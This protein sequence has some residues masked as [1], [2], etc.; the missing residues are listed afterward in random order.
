MAYWKDTWTFPT[1]IEYEFKFAGNYGAKGEKREKKKKATPEQIK[2]QN[3]L[4]REKRMRRLIEANFDPGDLWNTLKYPKGT[5]KPLKEVKKDMRKFLSDLRKEYKVRG[6][7]LRFVC[8]LHI[9]KQGGIHVHILV[10]RIRGQDTD[11]IIQKAWSHGQVNYQSIND[12]GGYKKLANYIVK[13]LAEEEEQQLSLFEQSE[14]K[15]FLRYS[16]SRNLIRPMPERKNY[17]R[18]T[19]RKLIDEGPK[20]TPGFY[21]EKDSLHFGV[22]PYTGMSYLHYR[23]CRIKSPEEKWKGGSRR[24]G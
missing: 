23:E 15:E 22:N 17:R 7:P 20:P 24:G 3:Q 12:F 5:R 4:N 14:R 2:K 8:R 9:G 10:N 11:I 6:K 1:S 21:I 13:E 18:W 19:L 16:T